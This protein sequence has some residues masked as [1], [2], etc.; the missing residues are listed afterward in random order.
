MKQSKAEQQL[1]YIHEIMN[2]ATH[3]FFFSPWQWIEW[4]LLV[5]AG[6]LATIFIR[7]E[8]TNLIILWLLIFVV[9]GAL[10]TWIWLG[11]AQKKDLNLSSP[12]YQKMWGVLG[13]FIIAGVILSIVFLQVKLPLYIPGLWLLLFGSCLFTLVLFGSRKDLNLFAITSY[14]AGAL[15]LTLLVNYSL[16]FLLIFFGVNSTLVGTFQLIKAKKKRGK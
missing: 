15:C 12:F 8:A 4:G 3:D 2:K 13:L 14:V 6:C 7:L 5:I 10:E 9:G 1:K 11:S 16:Y